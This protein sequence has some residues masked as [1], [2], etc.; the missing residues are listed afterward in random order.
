MNA[1][2][3]H[4]Q[5]RNAA[6]WSGLDWIDD[7]LPKGARAPALLSDMGSPSDAM[8]IWW[9]VQFWNT[10]VTPAY[11]LDGKDLAQSFPEAG[12]LDRERGTIASLA[13]ASFVVH[14]VPDR[15]FHLRGSRPLGSQ[16]SVELLSVPRGGRIDWLLDATG[17]AGLL[18][19]NRPANLRVFSGASGRR[20]RVSVSFTTN[21]QAA[22]PYR[23]R[24]AGSGVAKTGLVGVGKSEVAD[25]EVQAPP[26]GYAELKISASGRVHPDYPLGGLLITDVRSSPSR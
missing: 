12:G 2:G 20:Q 25:F 4:E 7:A 24:V 6:N 13:D 10:R 18:P 1:I 23:Y 16:D 21:F 5:K 15:R 3:G 19:V 17:D 8:P 9:H 14:A 26:G 22:G 11:S